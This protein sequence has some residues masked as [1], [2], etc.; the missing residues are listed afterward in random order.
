MYNVDKLIKTIINIADAI[1]ENKDYLTDLDRAIGDGDHGINLDRGFSSVKDFVLSLKKEEINDCG[2]ILNKTAM[3]LI[4]KVGGASGPLYGTAVLKMSSVVNKK[5][6]ISLSDG[7]NMLNAAIEGI[8]SR[9]KAE[10]NDKTML[11]TLIPAYETFNNLLKNGNIGEMKTKIL[12]A[13]KEGMEN[14]KN[15]PAKKGRASYLGERSVGNIDPGAA[16]SFLIIKTI[17]D[18]I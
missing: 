7:L 11:D 10:K 5:D 4:S 14:T 2:F 9:G 15:Y 1:K 13:A 6:H 12:E 3:I 17:V 8:I 18:S 16:S